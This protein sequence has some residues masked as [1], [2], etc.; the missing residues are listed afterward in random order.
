MKVPSR[1]HV[2][3]SAWKLIIQQLSQLLKRK[4]NHRHI[5]FRWTCHSTTDA[6]TVLIMISGFKRSQCSKPM[7]K[8]VSHVPARLHKS[9]FFLGG[10]N[11]PRP[12]TNMSSL[13]CFFPLLLAIKRLHD[14]TILSPQIQAVVPNQSVLLSPVQAVDLI[15]ALITDHLRIEKKKNY[16]LD[17]YFWRLKDL[18]ELLCRRA[19]LGKSS[20]SAKHGWA[21][22]SELRMSHYEVEH[23]KPYPGKTAAQRRRAVENSLVA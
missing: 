4:T 6:D 15:C 9:C 12:H 10:P 8:L 3:T 16:K 2:A 20:F 1:C 18:T 21:V 13:E 7:I 5:A 23:V 22:W 19:R 14:S 11:T 17:P